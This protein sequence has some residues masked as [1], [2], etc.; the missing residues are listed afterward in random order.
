MK[1]VQ[2][3]KFHLA[4]SHLILHGRSLGGYVV[5]QLAPHADLIVLDRTFS[6]IS[7]V[8]RE[9]YSRHAQKAF[10]LLGAISTRNTN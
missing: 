1:V 7:F 8:A 3:V 4:P 2:Y 9:M 6:K 10:C 5:Q